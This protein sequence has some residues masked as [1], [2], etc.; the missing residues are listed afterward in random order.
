MQGDFRARQALA[1]L[2]AAALLT[3][4]ALAASPQHVNGTYKGKTSAGKAFSAKVKTKK[5]SKLTLKASGTCQHGSFPA[6]PVTETFPYSSLKL[7]KKGKFNGSS[8][9][10]HNTPFGRDTFASTL[11]GTVKGHKIKGSFSLA[12]NRHLHDGTPVVCNYPKV[13]FKGKHK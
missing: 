13:T 5:I 1:G 9:S 11:K 7:S 6:Q 2:G 8:S 4:S 12:S 10:N 3:G